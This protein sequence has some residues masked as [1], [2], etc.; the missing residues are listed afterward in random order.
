MKR[1][2]TVITMSNDTWDP[3]L[4]PDPNYGDEYRVPVATLERFNAALVEFEAAH[5][6]LITKA[7]RVIVK[8][9]A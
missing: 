1:S 2:T 5:V 4:L 3:I 6:E 8:R 7:Q 9:H